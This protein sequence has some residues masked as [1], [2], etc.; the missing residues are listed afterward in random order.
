MKTIEDIEYLEGV[1]V[2]VRVDFNVPT[3]NGTV[4][5]DFRIRAA[6]PTIDWLAQKGAKVILISHMESADGDNPSLEPIAKHLGKLGRETLFVKNIKEANQLIEN[7]LK[8]GGCALLENLRFFDGE[9]ANDEKFA[10]ELASLGDIFVNEAFSVCH[11]KHASVVGVPKFLPSY[12]GLQLKEEVENLSKA[13]NPSH[14]FVFVLGGAKF[15]TKLPLLEKFLNIADTV[16]I[17]GALAT[18]FFKAKGYEVGH[19]LVSNDAT[20]I[21]AF[22]KNEKVIIPSDVVTEKGETKSADSLSAD[23]KIVDVG[24]MSIDSLK[25]IL[26]SAK[27][28]L[29]NGPFG[30]YEQGFKQSTLSLAGIIAD[31]THAGQ[32]ISIV[33]GGDTIAAVEELHIQDKISFISTGGGAMLEFLAQGSL[34]G[35]EAIG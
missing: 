25:K 17:G 13:F 35:I 16:F 9:K 14:P 15:E 21:L 2:L 30:V 10:R 26:D 4:V 6:L 27:L 7:S 11:R 1:K 20:G 5:N 8:S 19:S 33:G 32:I 12:A 3:K 24:P 22:L 23:D 29:W 28:V 34:P 31:L 18:D